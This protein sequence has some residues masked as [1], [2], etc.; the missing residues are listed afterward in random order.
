MARR[1]RVTTIE[2]LSFSI[3]SPSQLQLWQRAIGFDT[4]KT[5]FG[6]A[7]ATCLIFYFNSSTKRRA[8]HFY[9]FTAAA[10]FLVWHV[11]RVIMAAIPFHS[12]PIS[13]LLFL[14]V[15]F[16]F[17]NISTFHFHF[18]NCRFLTA[19]SL[20]STASPS[21]VTSCYSSHL[22]SVDH[23]CTIQWCGRSLKYRELY[24]SWHFHFLDLFTQ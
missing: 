4:P 11:E 22:A 21:A 14:T 5:K 20:D 19:G 12:L 1:P 2:M 15:T 3:T 17:R 7:V 23:R 16:P 24:I 8:V 13:P 18:L 9:I 10:P 6:A